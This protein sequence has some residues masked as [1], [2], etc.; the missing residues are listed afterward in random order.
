MCYRD[1]T[2]G[3]IATLR[4]NG[5]RAA[6][7]NSIKVKDGFNP[8]CYARVNFSGEIFLGLTDEQVIGT[9]GFIAPS[10]IYDATLQ[11]CT[12]GDNVHI[13]HVAE[14]IMNY[15]IDDHAYISNVGSV[16]CTGSRSFGNGTEVNVLDETGGR[17]VPIYDKLT[18][19]IAYIIAMYRHN[20]ALVGKLKKMI[21]D[22]ASEKKHASGI[23]GKYAKLTNIGS[24][25]DVNF[26]KESY[27]NGSSLLWD[28]TV[29]QKAFVGPNVVAEHFILASEAR[30]DKSA[31]VKNTFIGQA[32]T[33]SNG[34]VAHDS[35][36]FSNCVLECGEAAA[37]FA[38]PHTV[39]MHKSTLLI[40]GM[41]SFF[42]AGSGTNQS[43]HHYK[44]G[45]IHCGIMARGCKTGSN[46]YVM[47]PAR[48]GY[49]SAVLGSH[50]DHPDT[51]VLPYSYVIGADKKSIV[52]PAANLSTSGTIR[53]IMKWASRDCRSEELE[54]LDI[55]NYN[56]LNPLTT[57]LMYHAISFLNDYE[58]NPETAGLRNISIKSSA[59]ARGR[60]MYALGVDYF[61]GWA[62]VRKVLSLK[63]GN[64]QGLLQQLKPEGK[65]DIKEWI[66]AAGMIVPKSEIETICAGITAGKLDT[67]ESV[68]SALKGIDD[69][70][71][72]MAWDFVV[73]NFDKCYS[74]SIEDMTPRDIEAI[75]QRWT[76]TV[77]ALDRMRKTDALKDF[78]AKVM[79]GFGIDG[80]KE[81][82][83]ADFDAVRG[84]PEDNPQIRSIHNHYVDAIQ[85][86]LAA[87]RHL[88]QLIKLTEETKS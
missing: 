16:I 20:E 44:T 40:G 11:N 72:D 54:R 81:C 28:G 70:Y 82:A 37:V 48:F 33:V 80:D 49:F 83:R 84:E 8:D 7:W 63:P 35:L 67:L 21:G 74:Q 38:G 27:A 66:D 50:Y 2:P 45:P 29:G 65:T 22:Y 53:D 23:I 79:V 25:T 12:V 3:E 52:I 59:I 58:R 56:A 19:Q 60:Q 69:R 43:N 75:I 64:T 39:S 46:A 4:G 13:S 42:N 41:F 71:S 73:N 55:V 57:S 87:V 76:E 31:I 77:A 5:C 17:S 68:A 10:G 47:W 85:S 24:V 61:M 34:F 36:I 32:S 62:V 14:C 86:G 88:E 78:G 9:A 18:A 30:L 26:E 6:D 51:S 1:I 15:H